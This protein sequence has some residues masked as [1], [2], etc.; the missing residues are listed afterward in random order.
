MNPT[1]HLDHISETAL[2]WP[3]ENLTDTIVRKKDLLLKQTMG[4]GRQL[5]SVMVK[6]RKPVVQG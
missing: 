3:G 2:Q 6:I 4:G 1:V 5:E